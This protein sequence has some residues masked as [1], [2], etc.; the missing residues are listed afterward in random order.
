MCH[1]LLVV[2]ALVPLQE[3]VDILDPVFA[4]MD[5]VYTGH[6]K[7]RHAHLQELVFVQEERFLAIQRYFCRSAGFFSNL[8]FKSHKGVSLWLC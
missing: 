1:G 8:F 5:T 7:R 4:R 6:G 3:V 2:E